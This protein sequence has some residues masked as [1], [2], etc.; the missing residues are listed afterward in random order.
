MIIV[1]H[2]EETTY[3][4][5]LSLKAVR[6]LVGALIAGLSLFMMIACSY[7]QVWNESLEARSL[8]EEN[9]R[10]NEEMN[11]CA[12]ET[13]QLLAQFERVE[14]LTGKVT[15]RIGI[16]ATDESLPDYENRLYASRSGEGVFNRAA[17]NITRL[18][19]AVSEQSDSLNQ[20]NEQVEEYSRRLEAT[21]SIWPAWGRITSGFGNRRSPF[22]RYVGQFHKGIDIAAPY[23]T[24]IYA[25]AAGTVTG[26][27]YR[28]GWGNLITINHGYGYET[29][30]AHLSG[31]AVSG[32]ERVSKGQVIGY[33]GRTGRSTGVHLHYEVHV[34][35]VA[36]NPLNY[37]Y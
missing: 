37:I 17:H 26:A 7:R 14:S 35:G 9:R 27:G 3:S 21:P 8:R 19:Q 4:L 16:A 18:Q 31:F 5:R 29:Y 25:T 30:Y 10:Q 2:S 6:L 33:M 15:S 24:P 32:G 34:N 22:N 23:G 11:L 12:F 13:Q 36:V 20:I 28:G 1:P